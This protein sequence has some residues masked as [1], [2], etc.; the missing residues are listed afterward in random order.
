MNIDL[1]PFSAFV[2]ESSGAAARAISDS[3]TLTLDLG[4][5]PVHAA[6]GTSMSGS[7]SLGADAG[8]ATLRAQVVPAGGPVLTITF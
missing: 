6:F 2:L 1:L 3:Q 4:M 8:P 7:V 5:V